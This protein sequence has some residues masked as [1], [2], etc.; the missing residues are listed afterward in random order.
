MKNSE[1]RKIDR[2][3]K[4][5]DITNVYPYIKEPEV[6]DY[7]FS[8][9]LPL[10]TREELF[11]LY[12][13]VKFENK[14]IILKR[15]NEMETGIF[16]SFELILNVIEKETNLDRA[17]RLKKELLRTRDFHKIY[18]YLFKDLEFESEFKKEIETSLDYALGAISYLN[19]RGLKVYVE[20]VT[21]NYIEKVIISTKKPDV[22]ERYISIY[23][24]HDN[25]QLE[26]ILFELKNPRL[27]YVYVLK[28]NYSKDFD[29]DEAI[30]FIEN[31]GDL[32]LVIKTA[33]YLKPENLCNINAEDFFLS[34]GL[35]DLTENDKK[36]LINDTYEK[37]SS[38][39]VQEYKDSIVADRQKE[40]KNKFTRKNLHN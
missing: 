28:G 9:T 12:P 11:V 36:K 3:L 17:K 26:E 24:I 23:K 4:D 33:I 19:T 27:F 16:A 40:L 32:E 8:I 7:V 14:E 34:I 6:A 37:F 21:A 5:R 39:K 13:Y 10:L 30:K 29:K 31:S 35:L 25:S 20:E 15:L 22:L 38:K 1:K 18:N 2:L